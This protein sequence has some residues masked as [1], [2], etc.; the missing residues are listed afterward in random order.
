M[1]QDDGHLEEAIAK[2]KLAIDLD[3]ANAA[4]H[5]NLGLALEDTGN[6]EG[7]K[8]EYHM[9]LAIDKN[10]QKAR[11][12]LQALQDNLKQAAEEPVEKPPRG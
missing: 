10:D 11:E 1:L 7:A 3:K 9:A 2:Y 12:L 5:I 6:L 4:A 8:A